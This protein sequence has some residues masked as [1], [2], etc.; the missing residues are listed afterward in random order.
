M[1]DKKMANALARK[2]EKQNA[3][4][5]T[6]MEARA[7]GPD[8]VAVLAWDGNVFVRN[9][10]DGEHLAP[11]VEKFGPTEDEIKAC[12]DLDRIAAVKLEKRLVPCTACGEPVPNG[13]HVCP[14]FA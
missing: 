8:A 7:V 11:G 5:A 4:R 14:M 3:A 6:L 1:S 9:V 13:M 2:A 10:F 12:V